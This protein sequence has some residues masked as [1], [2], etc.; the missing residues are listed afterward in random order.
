MYKLLFTHGLQWYDTETFS[1]YGLSLSV[2]ASTKKFGPEEIKIF[3]VSESDIYLEE[4]LEQDE[5]DEKRA[6][7]P[8]PTTKTFTV[9]SGDKRILST[10]LRHTQ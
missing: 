3:L 10:L 7:E 2:T 1:T 9:E 4:I 8:S 6:L 5:H